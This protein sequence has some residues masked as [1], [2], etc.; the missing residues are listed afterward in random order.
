MSE[1]TAK[2]FWTAVTTMAAPAGFSIELDGRPVKTPAKALLVVPTQAMADAVAREWDAQ[3]D[4]I[5]PGTMPVT[6]GA[7][8]AVDKV[9]IQRAE[10][11]EML[12]AYGDSD[13]L[14]YRAAGPVEL[15]ARQA[16]RWDPL[17]AWAAKAHDAHLTSAEGVIHVPQDPVALRRLQLPLDDM[18]DFQIAAAHDLIS[19]SGSLVI[20]LAVI[21]GEMAAQDGWTLSRLDEEWQIEQWGEDDDAT[22]LE[23]IKN[24]AFLDAAA[25]Y[26]MTLT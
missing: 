22:A 24:Q 13:L 12:A 6:R 3:T 14:C 17:L 2:R 10:V 15:I 19:L 18:T 20:A 21:A 4:K 5:D 26:K 7:N 23:K 8:A 9:S 11:I 1:W 25:F 16:E